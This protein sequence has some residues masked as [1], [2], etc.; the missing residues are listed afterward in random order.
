M[1]NYYSI[2]QISENA[3]SEEIKHAYHKMARLF[4]PDNYNGAKADAEE[5][6]ALINEAYRVLSDIEKKREYDE[7]LH[8]YSRQ[9]ENKKRQSN[10]NES[11]NTQKPNEYESKSETTRKEDINGERNVN[12]GE[13]HKEKKQT[14]NEK[15]SSSCL[16]TIIEWIVYIGI[17]YF[18]V[19]HFELIDKAKELVNDVANISS[20]FTFDQEE[21]LDTEKGETPEVI[22]ENYL[23]YLKKGDSEEATGLFCNECEDDFSPMTIAEYN[24]TITD[25]YYV[26]DS[27]IPLY[28]LFE[29]IR[30]FDYE[31]ENVK[32]EYGKD[33]A[34]VNIYIVNCDICLL[35]AGILS[36]ES[37]ENTLESKSDIDIQKLVKRAIK[38]YGKDCI[39]DAEVT[40]KLIKDNEKWKIQCITPLKDFSTVV[41][42]Q[43]NDLIIQL[44]GENIDDYDDIETEEEDDVNLDY[45][46]SLLW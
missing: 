11:N 44:N 17:F 41:I 6:M 8:P 4:H 3:T 22:V 35:F 14:V 42:G 12:S 37:G 7:S 34:T 16:S 19:N 30:N 21:K 32:Y 2:L 39:I 20:S 31:I 28:P 5:Q 15:R 27:T 45:D 24:K 38:E 13:I 1:K 36:S 10:V 29:Q 23:N 18:I 40:F 25:V 46:E 26:V 43:A 33:E 9:D